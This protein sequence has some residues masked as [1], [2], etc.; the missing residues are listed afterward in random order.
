MGSGVKYFIESCISEIG[1]GLR[2]Q[3]LG[4]D[5]LEICSRLETEGMTP[6]I[7]LVTELCRKISIPVRVM[8]RTTEIGFEVSEVDTRKMMEAIQSFKELPIEGFV[9]GVMEDGMIN[10]RVMQ[11][12]IDLA[13]PFPITFHKAIDLSNNLMDDIEWL[14]QF[15]SIDTILTSGGAIQAIDGIEQIAKMKLVFKRDI[16]AGG[17]INPEVISRLHESLQLNWYHGSAVV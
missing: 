6:D 8:I 14:N 7:M 10:R 9:M 12:L 4:A 17:K 2:A 11:N 5:R 13:H 3:S 16:M 15:S 1:E